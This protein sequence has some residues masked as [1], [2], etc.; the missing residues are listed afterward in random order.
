MAISPRQV[1]MLS[2]TV[3]AALCGAAPALALPLLG[4]AQDFA[5]LGAATVTNT[6][7]TSLWG[8]LGVSPGSSITDDTP[9]R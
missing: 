6:G 3:V 7:A 1:S 9:R 4:S 8:D 2:M 5:E